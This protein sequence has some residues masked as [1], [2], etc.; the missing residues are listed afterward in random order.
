MWS[1]KSE[2]VTSFCATTDTHYLGYIKTAFRWRSS[3]LVFD[4]F[5]ETTQA[6]GRVWTLEGEGCSSGSC[7]WFTC[8]EPVSYCVL[9]F[10]CHSDQW[11]EWY[12]YSKSWSKTCS[13]ISTV[14]Y[15][16]TFQVVLCYTP[17]LEAMCLY[18]VSIH[19]VRNI[20]VGTSRLLGSN[21]KSCLLST[22][23]QACSVNATTSLKTTHDSHLTLKQDL[24]IWLFLMFGIQTQPCTSVEKST[25]K[26]R[27]SRVEHSWL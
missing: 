22:C 23:I 27:H 18:L 4:P 21:L 1:I 6:T 8:L 24:I 17:T 14:I 13:T 2:P 16:F 3:F 10:S 11:Y 20:C 25:L 12:C 26:L 5:T 15:I 19:T 9:C 7:C